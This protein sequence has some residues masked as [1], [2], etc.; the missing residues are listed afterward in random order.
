MGIND[1]I[2]CYSTISHLL[3]LTLIIKNTGQNTALEPL[4]I[5]AD[6]QLTRETRRE[7]IIVDPNISIERAQLPHVTYVSTL[8]EAFDLAQYHYV[9]IIDAILLTHTE[10]I[11]HIFTLMQSDN[12]VIV[13]KGKSA[14]SNLF[15]RI[16]SKY[17]RTLAVKLL[18][19]SEFAI[20]SSLAFSKT[21]VIKRINMDAEHSISDV[22]FLHKVKNAGYSIDAYEIADV[23]D[24]K[25][26]G[27]FDSLKQ[28]YS[29]IKLRIFPSDVIHF[30]TS[31]AGKKSKGFHHE[32]VEYMPY[33]NLPDE[34]IAIHQ[35]S[36]DQIII[37]LLLIGILGLG[38]AIDWKTTLIVIVAGL[39]FVYF[40]DLL[41]NLYLVFRS[42]S[43]KQEIS[44]SDEEIQRVAD[45]EWPTYTVFCPLYKEHHVV[46]QF[47]TAMKNLDYPKDKLQIMF[48]LEEKDT[49]TIDHIRN[50][51]LPSY[52]EIVVVPDTK[53]KTKPKAL[54]YGLL[55]TKGEYAVV[56]D[57]E[58]VPDTNQLKKVILAYEKVGAKVGCIQ[59][60][61]NFYNPHQ[62]LLTK[63]FTAEYSL[64]FDLVLTGLQSI[65]APIPLGGTSNHFRT[66]DLRNLHGWDSFNVT[67]DCDL[68]MRLIKNGLK[69]A[70]L[71]SITLEEANSDMVNWFWQRTRWIKGYVQTYLLHVRKPEEFKKKTHYWTFQ[72]VVGGKVMSMFIN[73]LMWLITI[74]YFVFYAHIGLLVEE[75]FPPLILYMGIISLIVGN[76]LYMYY[77]MIG[78]SRHGH[79]QLVKY[80]YLVPIYWLAMSVAAWVAVYKFI[81]EPFYWSKTKHGLHL[82]NKK[83]LEQAQ[84]KTGQLLV[85]APNA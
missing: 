8:K 76:F 43:K 46:P 33:S 2:Y 53:P 62:N 75:F 40:A 22:E 15:T 10:L 77:Y 35:L 12:D 23:R 80:M 54:N 30:D 39:T 37:S 27:L 78:C 56:Y 17:F 26:V 49:E 83:A 73:P 16:V 71:D 11:P 25:K 1:T 32:G 60:K 6:N 7:Y 70:I 61:L 44:I 74:S 18:P 51:E 24:Q 64:W 9:C 28:L 66:Q 13:A 4:I 14:Q 20:N 59:A 47:V 65:N 29:A 36:A 63:I 3:G 69:T 79:H 48:L 38:I 19:V 58:D 68:G 21:E 31:H 42:F 34:N 82:N 50:Y 84:L 55:K 81:T 52:F 5:Q 85:E 72:L 67:E 57:A 45:H 41:F